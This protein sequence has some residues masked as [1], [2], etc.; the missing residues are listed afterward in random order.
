MLSD[1]AYVPFVVS[2]CVLTVV[3]VRLSR[4]SRVEAELPDPASA[5]AAISRPLML[6]GLLGGLAYFVE[7][8]SRSSSAVH[9]K[10][11]HGASPG[12]RWPPRRP[13]PHSAARRDWRNSGQ[14]GP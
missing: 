11:V 10:S 3:T 14:P 4:L 2:A 6:L 8:A 9:L 1:A 7:N 13:L 5:L 12:R